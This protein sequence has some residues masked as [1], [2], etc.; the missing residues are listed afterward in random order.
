M[1]FH[2]HAG[3]P[4]GWK[5]AEIMWHPDPA[6]GES[7]AL[8]TDSNIMPERFTSSVSGSAHEYLYL[9]E[10]DAQVLFI[11]GDQGWRP[12]A[13]IAKGSFFGVAVPGTPDHVIYWTDTNRDGKVQIDEC[14]DSGASY[15]LENGWGGRIA[16]DLTMYMTGLARVRPDAVASDG[17]PVYSPAGRKVMGI[18]DTGDL[19]PVTDEHKLLLLSYKGYAGRTTGVVGIDTDTDQILWTYPLLYPGVHGSHDAPM[20]SPG[21][22]IG[23]LKICGVAHIDGAVGN[24]FAMR[25][26]L[27]QDFFMTTDG[28]YVG[29]LFRD[30]R[31]PS[32]DFPATVAQLAGTP[33]NNFTEGG[34]PFN[35]WFAKQADGA[36]RLTTGMAREAGMVLT[37][38]GLDTIQRFDGGDIMLDAAALAAAVQ[39]PDN[40][41][42]GAAS[43]PKSYTLQ[44][45]DRPP[46]LD[47]SAGGWTDIPGIR[48]ARQGSA[49]M[50]LVRLAYD[51][52]NLYLR[53][54]VTDPTPW[55][56][57][58]KDFTRLFKSGDAVDLQIGSGHATGHDP[59][60]GDVRLVIANYNGKPT[61]VLMSPG[62]SGAPLTYTS[63][64]M[65]KQFGCV[66]ILMNALVAERTSDHGYIVDAAIRWQDLQLSP[67]SG[68]SFS[69]D[70]GFISSDASGTSNTARTYWSNRRTNLV[71]DLPSEAWFDPS[72]WGTF[73][74]R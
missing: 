52:A 16:P 67:E 13:A 74:L 39:G 24:V 54:E 6:K 69:G 7:F 5:L 43:G 56:N 64:V 8:H 36:V 18:H 53:F 35:G 40:A 30:G 31:L 29:A 66:T 4:G 21:L 17:V 71:N 72:S 62:G 49:E 42:P 9:H 22:L 15:S 26:N 51:Q 14:Q 32:V 33:M 48:I 46:V 47:A 27:G 57:T 70:V 12:C 65:S 23:P 3:A 28:L 50:A 63:P 60:P 59:R 2:R 45:V 55:R 73:T 25:G 58:G 37:I 68:R 20:P 1:E 34:E 61:A 10:R 44:K 38:S 11:K 19:I 41:Q